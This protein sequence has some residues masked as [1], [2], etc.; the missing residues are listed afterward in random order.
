MYVPPAAGA[1]AIAGSLRRQHSV[2]DVQA[3]PARAQPAPKS[4]VQ[5]GTPTADGAQLGFGP[6]SLSSGQQLAVLDGN[7]HDCPMDRQLVLELQRIVDRPSP[8]RS[9]ATQLPSQQ[10][11][12][13][14][15]TSIGA[16]QPPSG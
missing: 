16:R 2:V 11:A 12:S 5:R 7:P 15:Q 10:S 4:P 6:M 1:Q 13:V 14:E 8:A 9:V 3:S